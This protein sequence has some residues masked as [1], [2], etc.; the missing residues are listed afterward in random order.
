MDNGE[1]Q[2][3][4][5]GLSV[6]TTTSYAA[7]RM[8]TIHMMAKPITNYPSQKTKEEHVYVKG[9]LEMA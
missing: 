6:S 2:S 7:R 8:Q 1:V 9:V 4:R 3:L 5:I